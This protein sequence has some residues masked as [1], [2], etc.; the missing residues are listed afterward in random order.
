MIFCQS[1]CNVTIVS[2]LHGEDVYFV[3]PPSYFTPSTSLQHFSNFYCVTNEFRPIFFHQEDSNS[4]TDLSGNKQ[5]SQ[6][7]FFSLVSIQ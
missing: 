5:I 4:E 7:L 6:Y 1:V 3:M 2:S